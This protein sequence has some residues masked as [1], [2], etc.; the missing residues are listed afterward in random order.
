MM[1]YCVSKAGLD[2]ITKQFALELGAH[3][4]RVNSVNPMW[5]LTE[6]I[7]GMIEA[8]PEF[9][10]RAKSI[11][12]MGRF[13]EFRDVVEPIMYML[14]EHSSMVTGTIHLVDGGLLSNIPV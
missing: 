9:E 4:I 10:K 6:A 2:M 8:C 3:N 5:V 7:Q 12:P 13:C 1:D 11:T 14:S